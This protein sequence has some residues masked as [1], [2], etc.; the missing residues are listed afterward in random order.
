MHCQRVEVEIELIKGPIPGVT[1]PELAWYG[2][3]PDASAARYPSQA[4]TIPYH[5]IPDVCDG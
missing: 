1:K 3:Y 2:R 5:T 4:S